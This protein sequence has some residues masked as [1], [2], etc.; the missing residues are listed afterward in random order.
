M[1]LTQEKLNLIERIIKNDRKFANNEDL[2]DDF[3]NEMC[4]RSMPIVNTITSDATLEAYLRKIATTSILNVLK[5]SGRLRRT[6]EGYTP[7]NEVSLDAPSQQSLSQDNYS[8]VV[9]SYPQAD[10][11][12]NPEDIAVQKEILQKIV[13]AI[14]LINEAEPDKQYLR[15]YKL[16]YDEGMTQKEIASELNLSQSEISKRLFKLM[17]KVKEAFN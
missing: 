10:Y 14:Y 12:S 11:D 2:Y 4:K 8:N 16:R 17:E 13:D 3:F 9:I 7:V 5:D 15:I 6:R 1:E